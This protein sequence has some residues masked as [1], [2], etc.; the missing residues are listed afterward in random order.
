M[1]GETKTVYDFSP[2]MFGETEQRAFPL[3]Q[4][5][6]VGF[7]I[8]TC[9]TSRS[10]NP[11]RITSTAA[12]DT[13]IVGDLLENLAVNFIAQLWIFKACA[14]DEADLMKFG[15]HGSAIVADAHSGRKV[16]C[17]VPP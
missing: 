10:V 3:Q 16:G 17:T 4:F 5:K 2:W 11:G 13:G 12:I 7:K 14:D 15:K 6:A 9:R 1:S 8:I